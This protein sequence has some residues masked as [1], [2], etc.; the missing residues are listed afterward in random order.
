MPVHA[1]PAHARRVAVTPALGTG[2]ELE[3]ALRRTQRPP[4][5]AAALDPMQQHVIS[6]DMDAMFPDG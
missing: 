5:D 1:D 2:Q 3:D 6:A 4:P